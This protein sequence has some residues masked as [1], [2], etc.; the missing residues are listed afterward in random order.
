MATTA[1]QLK[2]INLI[3]TDSN[4]IMHVSNYALLQACACCA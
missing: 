2:F 3:N 4:I 1:A